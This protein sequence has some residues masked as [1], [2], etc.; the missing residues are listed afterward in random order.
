[1]MLPRSY[2]FVPGDR[3]ERFEKAQASG[4][5]MVVFDLED[6]VSS[7]NK[8][9]ARL[10]VMQY[11]T[12]VEG[13]VCVR[14]NGFESSEFEADCDFLSMPAVSAIMLPKAEDKEVLELL[15]ARAHKGLVIIPL[16]ETARGLEAIRELAS[17]SSVQRVAFGSVD[18]QLDLGIEGDG[19]ELL[20]ARSQ[21]VLASRLAGIAAPIDGVTLAATDA[22]QVS[23]D[24]ALSRKL[25]F[26]AKLCIHPLQVDPVNAAFTMDE[27]DVRWAKGVLSIASASRAG[28][29]VFQGKLVDKPVLDRAHSILL[30]AE[31]GHHEN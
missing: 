4:A 6:A 24:S 17:A 12:R 30:R 1:M 23:S 19:I 29:L 5:D 8:S 2:L 10:Q 21:L 16:V 26:G 18:F 25:G 27:Q 14:I 3:P 22:H 7:K 11:L 31:L 20:F 28:A 15:T 13:R 9:L